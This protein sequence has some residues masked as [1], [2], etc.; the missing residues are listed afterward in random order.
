MLCATLAACDVTIGTAEMTVEEEKRFTVDGRVALDV[1]TFDGSIEV[2]GWDRKEVLVEVVKR[3]RDQAILDKIE[4]S[5]T[6]KGD[7]IKIDVPRPAIGEPVNWGNSPSASLVITAPIEST[8]VARSGDGSITLKRLNGKID[9]RT[10]DGSIRIS[11]V[12]G[13]LTARTGDGTIRAEEFEGAA[14]VE[15]GDGSVG[16]DGVLRRL[17]L[18]TQDGSVQ[19]KLRAGSAMDS[20]WSLTTGDGSMRIELPEG[21]NAEL[22]ATSGDG[23]VVIDEV[24]GSGVNAEKQEQ[25]DNAEHADDERAER[26]RRSAH[27]TLGSGGKTLMLRSGDGTITVRR[28]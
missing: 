6:Q 15:T 17:R 22:D 14:E 11:E 16:I 4:V 5:A 2:R 8:L 1:S 12:K 19:V 27:L 20:D 21:F 28:W 10:E 3:G 18:D 9:V 24:R 26:R 13:D 25:A 7:T 23:R